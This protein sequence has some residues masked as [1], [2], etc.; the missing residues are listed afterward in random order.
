MKSNTFARAAAGSVVERWQ[1]QPVSQVR[2]ADVLSRGRQA[3]R[4]Y[5]NH[6]DGRACGGDECFD[7]K[8]V[9]PTSPL[10]Q[11]VTKSSAAMQRLK[12]SLFA[13]SS[14]N[15][16]TPMTHHLSN[17]RHCVSAALCGIGVSCLEMI[18]TSGSESH[19]NSSPEFRLRLNKTNGR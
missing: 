12:C 13:T 14:S 19:R 5:H 1:Q 16:D 18:S 3:D 2:R 6:Y 9:S 10:L 4:Y 17:V 7:R 8:L 15:D 11:L